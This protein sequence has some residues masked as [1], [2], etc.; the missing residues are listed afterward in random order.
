MSGK[1]SIQP[2]FKWAGSK[3]KMLTSYAP[4]LTPETVPTRF[5]DLFA[6][7]LTMTLWAAETFPDIKLVIND[8]NTE[9]ID[10]YKQLQT[11]P[12]AVIAEWQKCVNQ[13]L[14]NDDKETRKAYYYKLREEY[15]KTPVTG[16]PERLAGILLFMLQ[17]NFNGMWK[18]YIMCNGRYSTPPGTCREKAPFFDPQRIHNIVKVLANADIYCGDFQNIPLQQGDLIYADPPYRSSVI[19]YKDAFTDADQTRLANWLT[20]SN[21][22][23]AYSN[24]D[25]HDGWYQTHFPQA[26]IIDLT[27]TYTAGRGTATHQVSEVLITNYTPKTV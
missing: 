8:A 9:L 10:L 19:D 20:S 5:I 6:G 12:T 14:K 22:P 26:N 11:N 18:T 3:Q 23:Y 21:L 4:Y 7:G 13:W 2:L 17:T 24:K 16:K 27:A 25:I 15:C 1:T